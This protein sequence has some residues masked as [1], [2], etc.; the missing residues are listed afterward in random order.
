MYK[1]VKFN[2]IEGIKTKGSK[3]Y[4]S[5][6]KL[7]EELLK[8][9]EMGKPT[10]AFTKMVILIATNISK[11]LH[12]VDEDDRD[13]CIQYAIMDCLTYGY[14][15][16]DEKKSKNAFA[17]LTSVCSNGFAKGWRKLGYHDLPASNK[18]RLD[19]GE[20]YSI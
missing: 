3:E 7:L 5:N 8:S 16:F 10:E 18:T 2:Q 20:V 14:Q 9:K 1:N 6:P 4:V 11:K 12:Y 15:K 13:D 19:S 17:Y